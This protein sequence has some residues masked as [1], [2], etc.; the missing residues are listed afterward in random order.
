MSKSPRK[1]K[2]TEAQRLERFVEMA[3]ELG[4]SEET[5]NFDEALKKVANAKPAAGRS[6]PSGKRSSS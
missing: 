6:H 5:P 4:A 3:K 2:L 1:P